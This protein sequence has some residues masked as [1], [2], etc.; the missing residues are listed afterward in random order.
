MKRLGGILTLVIFLVVVGCSDENEATSEVKEENGTVQTT[1]TSEPK[2]LEPPDLTITAGEK[3]I[4]PILGTYSWT[5]DNGDGTGEGIEADSEA[6][7]DLVRGTNPL[8]LTATS[9]VKFN[10]EEPPTHYILNI[11][12]EN[13]TVVRQTK[14][15]DPS[16][17]GIVIYEVLAHWEQGTA[18]YAFAVEVIAEP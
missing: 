7:P 9:S 10:F 13:Y 14:D 15:V 11:W 12:D 17:T 4:H 8:Q 2:V 18:S 6:P 3:T 16:E 5:I 1:Q